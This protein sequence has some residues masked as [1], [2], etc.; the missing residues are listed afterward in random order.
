MFYAFLA[1]LPILVVAV[2]LVGLRWPASRAMPLSLVTAAVLALFVWQVPGL[3]VLAFGIKGSLITV[4]LLYIIFGAIL[5]LNT[6]QQ[7]GAI[8][9]IRN[10]FHQISPDRRVQAIIVAWLF[11]SFIE[12]AA[13]FGTP[14]AVAVPL[15][16]AL[17]FPP[18]A[19]VV[20]GIV[21]QST[22]VSFGA[23][24]TPILVGVA[25]GLDV[26][27]GFGVDSVVQSAA[28]SWKLIADENIAATALLHTIGVRVAVIH[29][30]VGTF[31][32]LIL[33]C[34]LTRFFGRNQ[35]LREGLGC[36]KF[37]IFAAFAMTIPSVAT[38][39]LLGPD[40]PSLFGGMV[41]LVVVASAARRGFLIPAGEPWQFPEKED[42]S[43]DWQPVAEASAKTA[44]T[45]ADV[46]DTAQDDVSLSLIRSWLPYLILAVLLVMFRLPQ[47]PVKEWVNHP[48]V[49]F[50][51]DDLFGSTA[52]LKHTPLALPGT[53]FL[54]VSGLTFVLHGMSVK[55]YCKAV[56]DSLH[57]TAKASVALIFTVPMVQI[58]LGSGGGTA[59]LAKMPIVLAEQM[60]T[61]AGG[62]WPLLAPFAGGLGAFVA[63]SNTISNMMLSM[64]Q[65]GVGQ[66]IGCDPFWIVALQAVGGAAGNTI[67]VHNVV[68]AAAVVG[69]VGREGQIIR[70]T[71]P[72]FLYYA[73]F[74]GILGLIIVR[75]FS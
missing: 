40:F 12:G 18:L 56:A 72:V 44:R 11:G 30:A 73:T 45:A 23:L 15:L 52:D 43:A 59:G 75:V 25:N 31:I 27:T 1:S 69:L 48:N 28:V 17:G 68:A 49:T 9:V 6:L 66:Q 4:D 38:A 32:P 10:G 54:L 26:A 51:V 7:S 14:A 33:V 65:F 36:W 24:G 13:G 2:F 29:L 58:F 67:C 42:W 22:P 63:G 16:V 50:A 53:I 35:S 37:A 8:T 57:T 62:V 64:F 55:R 61:L 21:I 74:A 19:A 39:I 70:R 3:Q 60:A 71:L 47:L 5:L 20:C 34:L 41:G 46:A